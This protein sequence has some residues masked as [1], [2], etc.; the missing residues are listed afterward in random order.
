MWNLSI[1][2]KSV[3]ARN[4]HKK[5]KKMLENYKNLNFLQQLNAVN[6]SWVITCLNK[7]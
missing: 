7:D 4:A 1:Q 5:K 6:S 2:A 3:I